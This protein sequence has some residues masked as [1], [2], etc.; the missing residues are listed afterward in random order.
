MISKTNGGLS[1]ARNVGFKEAQADL[2]L[3]LDDDNRLLKPYL[4]EGISLM[5]AHTNVS[6]VYG[7]RI[8]FGGQNRVFCP[9]QIS[10]ESLRKTNRV[11]ACALIRKSLWEEVGGYDEEMTALEDWDFWLGAARLG[12]G[13][14]YIQEPCFEY[15]VREKSMIHSHL[16]NR[17]EHIKLIT[18]LSEKHGADISPL[19]DH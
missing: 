6:F 12:V 10:L 18:Y 9:G 7:N 14:A 1:S 19:V 5:K 3:P 15:R 2:I 8:D 17:E 13:A 16:N 4:T 11:D